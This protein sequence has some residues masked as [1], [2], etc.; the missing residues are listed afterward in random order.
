MKRM[1]V[2]AL[3]LVEIVGS[4]SAQRDDL[5]F[6]PKKKVKMSQEIKKCPKKNLLN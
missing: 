5:Y 1:V 3:L 6:V 2:A 4:A